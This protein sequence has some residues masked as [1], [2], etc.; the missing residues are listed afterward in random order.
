VIRVGEEGKRSD[1][2]SCCCLRDGTKLL[3]EITEMI[4]RKSV[5]RAVEIIKQLMKSEKIE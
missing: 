4:L 1:K 2:K 3:K 5:I